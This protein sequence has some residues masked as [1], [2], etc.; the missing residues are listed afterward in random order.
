MKPTFIINKQLADALSSQNE[1]EVDKVVSQ[2]RNFEGRKLQNQAEEL[3]IERQ[4]K[5]IRK[6]KAGYLK[7]DK[8]KELEDL[9][10]KKREIEEDKLKLQHELKNLDKGM[11]R[12]NYS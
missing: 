10:R 4:L 2:A 3:A 9:D 12:S 11:I 8:K 5:E 7:E 1:R 6:E